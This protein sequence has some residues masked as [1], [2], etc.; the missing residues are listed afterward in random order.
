MVRRRGWEWNTL[1]TRAENGEEAVPTPATLWSVWF[2]A[3]LLPVLLIPGGAFYHTY[4]YWWALVPAAGLV[5]HVGTSGLRYRQG[6]TDRRARLVRTGAMLLLVSAL[7]H[8]AAFS[9]VALSKTDTFAPAE[10]DA[11]QEG[12]SSEAVAKALRP[13]L[14]GEDVLL[15]HDDYGGF[16]VP[17]HTRHVTREQASIIN[18]LRPATL[19]SGDVL[20]TPVGPAGLPASVADEWRRV[21]TV[22]S[23][24]ET[25][26]IYRRS[27]RTRE[28]AARAPG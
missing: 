26:H 7:V 16:A 27:W 4:Y 8:A 25:S 17:A 18:E 22:S 13:I 20:V 10:S 23:A 15:V 2:V 9:G 5:A 6:A 14:D 21:K 19:E 24:G 28:S 11:L 3:G 12:V 1:V